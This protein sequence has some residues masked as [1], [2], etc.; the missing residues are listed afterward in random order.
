MK[1]HVDSGMRLFQ[2]VVQDF[3]HR[4]PPPARDFYV[5]KSGRGIR[6]VVETIPER[7]LFKWAK[8]GK[9]AISWSRKFGS[10]VSCRK[11]DSHLRRLEMISHLS[12]DMKPIEVEISVDEF[13]IGRDLEIKPAERSKKMDVEDI[14][15]KQFVC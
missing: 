14:D 11:V 15:K 13:I 5:D 9:R 3:A 7:T 8:D 4:Q 2:I 12:V 10:V 1:S 6:E